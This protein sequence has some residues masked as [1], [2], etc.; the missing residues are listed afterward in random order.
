MAEYKAKLIPC[1]KNMGGYDKYSETEHEVGKWI[2]GSVL[3]EKTIDC[4]ALPNVA[5]KNVAH[6]ISNLKRIVNYTGYAYS[7]TNANS[8]PIPFATNS[9]FARVNSS[10]TDY[11]AISTGSDLSAYN[12]TYITIRYTKT[13]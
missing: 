1:A 5:S 13:A 11:L 2:D 12:E 8:I 10:G 6:G 9:V 3:Y 4:G 7:T